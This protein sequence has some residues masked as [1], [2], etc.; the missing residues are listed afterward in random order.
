[1]LTGTEHVR[2]DILFVSGHERLQVKGE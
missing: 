2:R 1:L